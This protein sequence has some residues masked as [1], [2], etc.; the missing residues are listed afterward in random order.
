MRHILLSVPLMGGAERTHAG[1]A[2]TSKWL[3]TVGPNITAF[4]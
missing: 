4:E 1:Q 2:F 3:S